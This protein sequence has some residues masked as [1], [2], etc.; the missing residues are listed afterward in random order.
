M[1]KKTNITFKIYYIFFM[2]I[3]FFT[4]NDSYHSPYLRKKKDY[5]NI[6]LYEKTA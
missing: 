2:F 3:S 4:F 1:L 6:F 5:I